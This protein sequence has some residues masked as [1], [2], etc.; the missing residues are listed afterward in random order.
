MIHLYIY[1]KFTTKAPCFGAASWHGLTFKFLDS[2]VS[3]LLVLLATLLPMQGAIFADSG[4]SFEWATVGDPGNSIDPLIGVPTG[5]RHP[6]PERGAVPY[7]YSISKYETTIGQYTA[8]LNA[9]AKSDPHGQYDPDLGTQDTIRGIARS[10][11]DGSYVYHVRSVYSGAGGA[12]ISA[13]LPVTHVGFVD[14]ARFVNWL[15]N[16]Q[17]SGSTETGAYSISK[18]QITRASRSGGMVTITTAQPHTLSIGDWVSVSVNGDNRLAGSFRVTAITDTTFS[19]LL[20]GDDFAGQQMTGS[21]TG[22]SATHKP[23]ARYWIPTENEWYKAAYYDPSPQGPVDDYWL[24]PTRRETYS[25]GQANFFDGV[26]AVTGRPG[27]SHFTTYLTDVRDYGTY[28]SYYGTFNQ[29]GNVEE[30]TEGDSFSQGPNP[31]GGA[32]FGGP[33]LYEMMSFNTDEQLYSPG[34]VA[35]SSGTGFRVATVANPPAGTLSGGDKIR[36]YPRAGYNSRMVGG[37]FEITR[38]RGF[39]YTVLHT[40]TEVPPTAWTEVNVNLGHADLLRYRSPNGSY[41]NVA[42][43]EF[44]RAGAKIPGAAAGTPGSWSRNDNDTFRAAFDGN[45]STFFDAPQSDGAYVEIDTGFVTQDFDVLRLREGS[46]QFDGAIGRAGERAFVRARPTPPGHYFAGWTG[47]TDILDDPF[48]PHTWA[49]FPGIGIDMWL[50]VTYKPLPPGTAQLEVIGGSGYGVYPTATIVTVSADPPRE[51]HLEFAG[52]GGDIAILANPFLPTTTAIIP[53][54][55][56]GISAQYNAAGLRDKIRFHPRSGFTER[57]VGGVFEGTSGDPLT[58]PYKTFYTVTSNPPEGWS[59]VSVDLTNR[60]PL[61][62]PHYRYLRYRGPDGS[63]GN[64][65]EIEFYRNEVKLAGTGFG[66]RGSWN[67]GGDT[68]SKALDGEVNTFFDAPTESGNYVGIDTAAT[69]SAD[70]IRFYPRSG[71]TERMVG[72]VFEGTNGDRVNGPYTTIHTITNNPQLAWNEVSVG[73]GDYRYLRYRGPNGSYGNVAEIEFYRGEVKVAGAGFGT[74][75]SWS[76]SGNIFERALDGD[77]NT[78]FDAPTE[79]GNYVGIDTQ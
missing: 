42:E 6:T 9:V 16:G 34:I 78:I 69:P 68:Y 39:S 37:V 75:G 43:I 49:T 8:F 25:S 63:Y 72:G 23:D 5:G 54:V 35:R 70:K 77:V 40:I 51:P 13:D 46:G 41:G 76:N 17:G 36:Y 73:L 24:F 15:H 66:T 48:S 29:A 52:W 33:Q 10:G 50:T 32:W 74:P 65:A 71:F 7:V 61:E 18:G 22:I 3:R 45:I 60:V 4:V 64:V 56:V 47:F 30:W 20:A 79:S 19:Y 14:A 53:S 44:Y 59:E 55:N 11:T 27:V 38:D 58:G 67:N 2:M 26:F 57:M 12:R 31:R 28:A 1:N 62:Q 21:I